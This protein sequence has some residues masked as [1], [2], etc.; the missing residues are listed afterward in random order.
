[1]YIVIRMYPTSIAINVRLHVQIRCVLDAAKF[2][3]CDG[4][5]FTVLQASLELFNRPTS[6]G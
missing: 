3:L 5:R 1:M 6:H 4:S 2:T